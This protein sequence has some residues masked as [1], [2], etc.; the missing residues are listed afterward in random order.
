MKVW[1]VG[2]LIAK[3]PVTVN[4]IVNELEMKW[5]SGM[6]GVMPVFESAK[7]AEAYAKKSRKKFMVGNERSGQLRRR[8]WG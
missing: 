1:V 7:D 6:L 4:G 8:R 2:E 5:A 3:M